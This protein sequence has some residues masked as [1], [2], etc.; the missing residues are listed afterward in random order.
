MKVL[1]GAGVVD[2]RGSLAGATASRNTYGSYWRS[3]VTP[4]N[5]N[6]NAQQLVRQELATMA[7]AWAGL[8][9]AQRLSWNEISGSWSTTNIFGNS[10]KWTGFNFFGH[11][12]R[13]LQAIGEAQITDP[14]LPGTVVGFT[15]LAVVADTGG[16]TMNVTLSA[17]TAAGQST[18]L[19]ASAAFSAGVSF[20]GTSLRQIRVLTA[21]DGAVVDVAAEYITKYGALPPVG[22]KIFIRVR[23]VVIATGQPGTTIQASDI[24]I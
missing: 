13:Y 18:I 24:A 12:N 4:I 19:E 14:V 9:D 3:K 16:G 10:Q 22:S 2:A 20:P 23:P 5:R 11:L 6:T 17:A 8:T 21:G 7:Q 15:S 1:Y